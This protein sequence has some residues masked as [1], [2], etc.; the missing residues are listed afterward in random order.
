M[1]KFDF[2]PVGPL[3]CNCILLWNPELLIGN[4]IDPGGDS[5]KIAHKV[6]LAGITIKAILHTH[7]HFDHI[8]ATKELQDL[9]QC[10]A[11]F[12][13]KDRYLIDKLDIQTRM[14][15]VD[16]IAKPTISLFNHGDIRY[17]LK[18]LHTPGHTPGSCCFLIN[19]SQGQVL[20][21]GDTIFRDSVGRTDTEGGNA[22]QLMLSIQRELSPLDGNT[23]VI[24]GHGLYT[25]LGD[26]P[27]VRYSKIQLRV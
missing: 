2:F 27:Y 24:P 21:S 16:R 12:H 6:Q 11:Y 22:E 19:S 8:G 3:G 18:V 26:N 17:G 20:F 7:A 25:T 13:E 4:I 5:H 23:L 1:V 14:Y 9:W 15:N 10:P